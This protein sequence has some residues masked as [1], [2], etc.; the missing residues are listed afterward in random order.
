M[1]GIFGSLIVRIPRKED[2]NSRYFDTDLA[3]HVVVINDWMNEEATERFPGRSTGVN[4]G[5]LPDAMLINGKG[6]IVSIF[7]LRVIK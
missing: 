2:P 1:D 3:S 4:V 7:L 5:Q 6:L